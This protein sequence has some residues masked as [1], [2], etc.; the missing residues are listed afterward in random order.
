M[1]NP[2][3]GEAQGPES[4]VQAPRAPDRTSRVHDRP[5]AR[6]S[7]LSVLPA[8]RRAQGVAGQ[9]GSDHLACPHGVPRLAASASA[10]SEARTGSGRSGQSARNR[11]RARSWGH[12]SGAGTGEGGS[13]WGAGGSGTCRNSL[14]GLS[15]CGVRSVG[16]EPIGCRF[17]SC[18]AH[19]TPPS[20]SRSLS[21]SQRVEGAGKGKGIG[22]DAIDSRRRQLGGALLLHRLRL[23]RLA[24]HGLDDPHA[25][26]RG[27]RH[28]LP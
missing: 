2:T 9:G 19:F 6:R 21:L 3:C 11:A 4:G 18:R 12:G 16:F 23:L 5:R 13:D 20:P 1:A 26:E 14:V 22:R 25:D 10:R 8:S 15:C 24:P 17:K 28:A 27:V 7:L